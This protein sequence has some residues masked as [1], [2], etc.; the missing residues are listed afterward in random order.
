ML[1]KHRLTRIVATLGPASDD[2]RTIS[3]LIHAGMDVARLNMSHGDHDSHRRLARKVRQEARRA[4][5]TIGVMVDLQGPKVRLGRFSHPARLRRGQQVVLT[6]HAREA[7]P[8]RG[9]LPVDYRHLPL[10]TE[11]GHEILLA[12]GAVRLRVER[13]RGH[14]VTCK[15]LEGKELLPRAGFSLPQATAVR[16]PLTAKDKR[17][18]QFAVDLGADFI[19][20]SFVRRE[21]DLRQARRLIRRYGGRQK[22]IAKIET[23]PAV[24]NLDDIITASDSVMVARG[25]LGV[26][27]PPER[28]PI[29]QKRIIRA[30]SMAGKPVIT[31]TQMLES[32]RTASRPT[33]AEASDVANAVLD[34]TWAVMLSAETASGEYP[35]ESVKMMDRIIRE[36]EQYFYIVPRRRRPQLALSVSEGIAE[37]GSW[38]AFDIGAEAIVALTRSGATAAQVARFHP[39][40]PIFA[41]TPDRQVLHQMTLFRGVIPR[42]LPEQKTFSGAIERACED[43]RKRRDATRGDMVVVLGGDPHEP[44]GVTN[45]LVVHR[46]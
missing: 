17:D 20:L 4:G 21:E 22:L 37:A 6:T 33:R 32:M 28:V 43:L 24:H 18:L 45:R 46:V 38:I 5:R 15:V 27:L 10:E 29:E 34:E 12:D 9:V 40:L 26:E 8:D 16:S 36:A 44:M 2:S 35:V 19:A 25:D 39:S 30:S 11:R 14:R 13:I 31:A 3:R 42:Y 1:L 23:V 41:Y 7:D